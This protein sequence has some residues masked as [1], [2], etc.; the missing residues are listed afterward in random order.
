MSE[1]PAYERP[2]RFSWH[3]DD[4]E[5]RLGI[6]GARHTQ[7]NLFVWALVAVLLTAAFYGVLRIFPDSYLAQ[8]FT[9]RGL[10]Q[11]V[12]VFFSSW[13]LLILLIKWTKVRVQRKALLFRDLV[14]EE[15]DFVL[16]PATVAQVLGYLRQE[17]DDPSRFLLFARIEQAL[18]NL[19]NMGQV[20]DLA[21]V[22]QAQA[23]NDEDVM[24]SS[25]SVVKGLIWAI[26]VLGFIGTVQ[27]LGQAIGSFGGVISQA[28][29]I[30]ALKPE[31]QKV[32][33]GLATAFDTTFVALVA[34][35]IIQLLLVMVRKSEEQMMDQL[36]QF[37]QRHL[38]GRLRLMPFDQRG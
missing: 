33:G 12:T 4:F 26:P 17:C 29:S 19:K 34:A 16:S 15:I 1:I 24:E 25:Y 20:A 14:P 3:R 2:A 36:K 22:L 21:N 37:C 6:G 18:S 8:V 7:V 35:L 28:A 9:Q 27:G 32:T 23:D 11:Y 30:E 38:I 13:A 10:V 5:A 31:L